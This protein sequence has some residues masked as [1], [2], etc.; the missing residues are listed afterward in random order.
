MR[1]GRLAFGRRT[2]PLASPAAPGGPRPPWNPAGSTTVET[3]PEAGRT[4]LA[5]LHP[6]VTR[7]RVPWRLLHLPVPGTRLLRRRSSRTAHFRVCPAR[8]SKQTNPPPPPL[9]SAAGPEFSG[10]RSHSVP[11]LGGDRWRSTSLRL[12]SYPAS[13]SPKALGSAWGRWADR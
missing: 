11:L 8:C 5:V 6:R 7:R 12:R 3:E 2:P 13:G 10:W 9:D 1:R 4:L